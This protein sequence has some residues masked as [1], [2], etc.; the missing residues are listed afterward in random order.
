MSNGKK[1]TL[2]VLSFGVV[3]TVVARMKSNVHIYLF[4]QIPLTGTL[5]GAALLLSSICLSSLAFSSILRIHQ[6]KA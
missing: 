2:K 5:F 6:P 1:A 4:K 3:F